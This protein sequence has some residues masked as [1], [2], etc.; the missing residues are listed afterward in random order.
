MTQWESEADV[1]VCGF[2]G[3]GA[4]AA[5]EAADAGAE[6]R[7][8]DRF[9][10]G[11][12]TRKSGGVIYAGG[13]TSVQR[14]AAVEDSVDAMLAYL[15]DE[16]GGAVSEAALR[17]FC[18]ES[19]DHVEWLQSL[20]LEFPARLYAA[21]TTQPPDDFGLYYSG[22]ER[23]RASIAPPAARGHVPAGRGMT[24]RVLFETLARSVAARGI[25]IG[26]R[27]RVVELIERS[28][29]V[30]G[31][32]ALELPDRP[33][34]HAAHDALS[35]LGMASEAARARLARFEA[36]FGRR[37]R[38]HARRGVVLATGGF[39]YSP[40]M[41]RT[42]APAYAGCMPLGTVTDDG[43]GIRMGLRVGA[44]TAHMN[45]CA[46]SRFFAPPA[47]FARGVLVDAQGERICDESLYGATI[48][49]HIAE[50][51]GRAFLVLDRSIVE[52]IEKELE[53]EESITD[54]PFSSILAGDVN[55]LLF[56]AYCA[57]V[58]LHLNRERA[59]SV[60]ELEH[61]CGLPPGSLERTLAR[62]GD[63]AEGVDPLGKE[64]ALLGRIAT[65]PFYAVRCDLDSRLFPGPCITLG[66]LRV[67][68][69]TG[70][71]LRE[72]GS[73]IEG[74]HAVGR[75]AV[76]V[77][78]WSYVSG[79]SLAD[80]IHSGRRAGRAAASAHVG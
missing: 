20:G 21:K 66:G 22:N 57:H 72:D 55:H 58:N 56:R 7:I 43:S 51:G 36:R 19:R 40:E 34:L 5:I 79:L 17:R 1:V 33:G 70:L 8:V 71:V 60:P 12:A 46:A 61:V 29:R 73:A 50:R 31:I 27:T 6:V 74:L 41:M 26:R 49:A 63:H 52:R 67:D 35:A 14:R 30:V 15:A 28:G 80:C 38:I 75:T 39:V 76:G 13:G 54:R 62:Y 11:G 10:G 3:A 48:S 16:T 42:H 23:Q 18:E 37:I 78:S 44:A 9:D 65:P 77:A 68:E 45:R 4:C 64:R 25:P 69:N 47:S 59:T 2:G 24:G 32:E 53:E